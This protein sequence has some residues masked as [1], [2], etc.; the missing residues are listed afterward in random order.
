M[1]SIFSSE[2]A[3]AP[4]RDE[5]ADSKLFPLADAAA[6]EAA[7]IELGALAGKAC[8]PLDCFKKEAWNPTPFSPWEGS[9]LR[10]RAHGIAHGR[11]AEQT[12]RFFCIL[13]E[14]SLDHSQ[15]ARVLL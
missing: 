9:I 7:V 11:P 5:P 14:H 10:E 4:E 8:P 6:P 15:R 1:T 13:V 2:P 12:R 3:S